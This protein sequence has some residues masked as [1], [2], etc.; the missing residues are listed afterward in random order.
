LLK[1]S[2]LPVIT[3]LDNALQYLGEREAQGLQLIRDKLR[4]FQ[5]WERISRVGEFGETFD[6][7]IHR[8]IG[9]DERGEYPSRMVV[10][11]LRPG[12]R[13]EDHVVQK[14]EVIVNR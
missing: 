2:L 8:A 1:R 5:K 9:T 13:V 14:A 3:E 4:D 11:V 7:D 10:E 6:P 12:Y